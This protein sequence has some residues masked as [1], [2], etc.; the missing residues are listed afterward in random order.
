MKKRLLEVSCGFKRNIKFTLFFNAQKHGHLWW[1]IH[2]E[3]LSD[4]HCKEI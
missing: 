3:K 2:C 4:P 1:V